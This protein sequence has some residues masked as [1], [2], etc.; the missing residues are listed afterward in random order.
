MR[1]ALFSLYF[2]LRV[3]HHGFG[4]PRKKKKGDRVERETL[5]E[6]LRP[7]VAFSVVDEEGV[8]SVS[9]EDLKVNIL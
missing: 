8:G 4:A 5:K 7:W 2:L 1:V 6:F 3:V 9:A